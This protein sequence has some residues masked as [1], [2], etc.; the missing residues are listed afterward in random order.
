M[1]TKQY[2]T[3][4]K[5]KD[6]NNYAQEGGSAF[7]S[8]AMQYATGNDIGAAMGMFSA[9]KNM[10]MQKRSVTLTRT[11][12]TSPADVISWSGCKDVQTVS[13]L[14]QRISLKRSPP[15]PLRRDRLL[16]PCHM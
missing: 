8:S 14:V 15:T 16:A 6:P 4:G 1:L 3:Q 2:S 9:A 5:V 7:L 10:F 13:C 12:N 11:Q